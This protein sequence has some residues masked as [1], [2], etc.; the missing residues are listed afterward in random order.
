MTLLVISPDFISH[1]SPLA[2]VARA[3]KKA[4]QRVVIATGVNMAP[5]AEAEGFEWQML[6]LSQSA[7]SGIAVQNPAIL[8]F[9]NATREGPIATIRCQALDREKDLLWH[10]VEVAKQ[11]AQLCEEINPKDI[12]V[13]HVSFNSTLGVYATGRPFTTLVPGHPS[14]LP[15]GNERYGIPAAWP[16][17]MQPEPNEL[18]QQEQITDRV[19]TAFTDRWNAALSIIAPTMEPVKD[20]F[21]VHG[22][23]VLFNSPKQYHAMNRLQ[24]LPVHHQ[25]IGP[26]IRDDMLEV[27]HRQWLDDADGRPIVYV[28]LGT[29]LS[30]RADVLSKISTALQRANV[31]VAMAIGTTP[32]STFEPLP[33]GWL[34]APSLPQVG[35]LRAC[36]IIIHHGGNNSVQEALGMGVRQIILPFSTDQFANACDLERTGQAQVI[37]PN[38]ICP[39]TLAEL[40]HTTM[41]LP[42]P[43]KLLPDFPV[44]F[45]SALTD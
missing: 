13:D 17:C 33:H 23:Q 42:K 38:H 6:Q 31:R 45:A 30:H 10:P 37:S 39:Q 9:L 1:Y 44:V 34:V 25:F 16:T 15:V 22:D 5:F 26:L 4:G 12:L 32:M 28:A 41:A 24:H 11:I 18:A 7:N 43:K 27:S 3:V 29:F 35:L 8:R 20:A 2:V 36:D 21:R 19:T 40:I 14:Q